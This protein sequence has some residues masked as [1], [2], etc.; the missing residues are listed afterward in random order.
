MV[1][2][3]GHDKIHPRR[4]GL[5]S[6]A[7]FFINKP[8]IG[9]AKNPF[10]GTFIE[11]ENTSYSY[12]FIEDNKD[13]LGAVLRTVQNRKPIFVLVGNHCTLQEAIDICINFSMPNIRIPLVTNLPDLYAKKLKNLLSFAK[14]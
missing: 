13:I 5:A 10:I 7:S 4:M 12:S 6:L 8:T 2:F 14:V 11:Q 9:I 1:V 3:D